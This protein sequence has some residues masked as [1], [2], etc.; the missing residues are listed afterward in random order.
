[1]IFIKIFLLTSIIINISVALFVLLKSPTKSLNRNYFLLTLFAVIWE[2]TLLIELFINNVEILQ[3]STRI[4]FIASGFVPPMIILVLFS[5]LERSFSLK[6]ITLIFSPTIIIG[7][8]IAF[9]GV[10]TNLIITSYGLNFTPNFLYPFFVVY[11]ILYT[12]YIFYYSFSNYRKSS[13]IKKIQFKYILF[14]ILV[15]FAIAITTNL[16]I[17]TLSIYF[18][19]FSKDVSALATYFGPGFSFICSFSIAYAITRYRLFGIKFILKKASTYLLSLVVLLT[20]YTA[21]ILFAQQTLIKKYNCN[22]TVIIIA[23]VLIIALTFEPIRRLN[24]KAIDKIFYPKKADVLEIKKIKNTQQL[25]SKD[26]NDLIS[27]LVRN[28]LPLVSLTKIRLLLPDKKT[29]T[30]NIAYPDKAKINL[31]N[32]DTLISFLNNEAEILLTQEIPFFLE[33]KGKTEKNSLELIFNDLKNNDIGAIIPI[34]DKNE[35]MVIFLVTDKDR[36]SPFNKEEV[37]MMNQFKIN[38][39]PLLMSMVMYKLGVEGIKQ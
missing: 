17:E 14:G 33:E 9:F 5:F 23:S 18:K 7:V 30:Y 8:L 26:F 10:A 34:G 1:M 24:K 13:G 11:F 2:I 28:Y 19:I 37:D 38:C 31:S 35:I 16:I 27:E 4:V 25:I 20:I 36:K 3:I 15:S 12:F 32:K 6:K 39:S 22:E 29:K 21:L